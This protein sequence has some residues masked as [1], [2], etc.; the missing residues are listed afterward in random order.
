MENRPVVESRAVEEGRGSLRLIEVKALPVL[1]RPQVNL[2]N[3]HPRPPLDTKRTQVCPKQEAPT[4]GLGIPPFKKVPDALLFPRS[5]GR[6]AAEV[7]RARRLGRVRLNRRSP[8][9]LVRTERPRRFE[10]PNSKPDRVHS[11]GQMLNPMSQHR[12]QTKRLTGPLLH[13]RLRRQSSTGRRFVRMGRRKSLPLQ[14]YLWPSGERIW[15]E[16]GAY[17]MEFNRTQAQSTSPTRQEPASLPGPTGLPWEAGSPR[18]IR[19]EPASPPEPAG[20]P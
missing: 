4:A 3:R 8:V 13:S 18:L 15:Q 19:Q 12:C 11:A 10:R 14:A 17:P 2:E 20:L 9:S 7:C 1:L 6:A 5:S 16:N